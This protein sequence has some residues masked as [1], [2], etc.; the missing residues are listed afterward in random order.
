MVDWFVPLEAQEEVWATSA[1]LSPRDPR[2]R[3][4]RPRL[5]TL[6]EVFDAAAADPTPHVFVAYT[7]KGYGLPLA[8]HKD[9]N[10]GLMNPTQL[11]TLALRPSRFEN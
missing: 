4:A 7:I 9:N 3:P 8:G 6:V 11:K 1:T 5:E 10:A 2:L